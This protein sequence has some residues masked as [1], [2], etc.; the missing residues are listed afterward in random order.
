MKNLL[1]LLATILLMACGSDPDSHL[2]RLN[3]GEKWKVNE[4]M[5]PFIEE[6]NTILQT[7]IDNGGTDYHA[8]ADKLEKQNW[9]LIKN[10]TMEGESHD[11]LHNWL[12]PHM[13]MINELEDAENQEQA[14]EKV[15]KLAAS[16]EV[17][18][19]HFK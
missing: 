8:L 13:A 4:E 12:H 11:Q 2:L 19:A 17:Y 15:E 10:C 6:G 14:K 3:N 18:H 16:F 1:L 7:Y 9:Q 5:T